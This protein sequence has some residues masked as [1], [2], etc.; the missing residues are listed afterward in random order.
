MRVTT[1]DII[2]EEDFDES[3]YDSEYD[4]EDASRL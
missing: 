3:S 2:T 1:E 4:D